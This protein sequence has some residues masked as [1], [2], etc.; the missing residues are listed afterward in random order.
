MAIDTLAT[1][2]V[3]IDSLGHEGDGI[4]DTSSGRVFVPL[5][6]PGEEVRVERNGE[7]ARLLEVLSP[8]RDR[9]APICRHFGTCGGCALQHL[10]MPAYL[11]W[12]REQ[13][14]RAFAQRGIEAPV[15]PTFAAGPRTRRRAVLTAIGVS[16]G[17]R[18]GF[19]IGRSHELLDIEECPVLVPAIESRIPQLRKLAG[20]VFQPG[21][22]GRLT[23]LAADNG[24]DIAIDRERWK[25]P[26]RALLQKLAAFGA[27]SW[28]ARI[29]L[30]GEPVVQNLRPQIGA[31]GVTLYPTPSG[32]TQASR[33]AEA[34][35]A[36]AI[37]AGAERGAPIADLF[38]GIGT[39]T[40]RLARHAP[41]T[42]VESDR[43]AVAALSDAARFSTGLKPI[44]AER[45]DLFQSPLAP[46]ELKSFGT[47]VFDPPRAGAS[48][49]AE[50]LAQSKVPRVVAVS[51]NP[52]T[53]ARDTR[54]LLDGG[55]RLTRV[56]P[57]DQFTWSAEIEAVATFER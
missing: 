16:G 8:H 51:C 14:I 19:H 15:E 2:T 17:A 4:A 7:R 32:F 31:G 18:L 33:E 28:I 25:P 43:A 5:A 1:E 37:L 48:R 10:A 49:Q 50:A 20:I 45:R 52:A 12:K 55:Y 53:L 54:I 34:A 42:A 13:L 26:D 21:Q 9:V 6:L 36:D 30:D 11:D 47:V 57:I 56:L 46:H 3:T 22:R 35:M 29:S 39:F 38:A 44:K 40:L 41:V 27:A 24:L 23:V